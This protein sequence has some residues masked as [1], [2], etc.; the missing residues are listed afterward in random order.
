MATSIDQYNPVFLPEEPPFLTEKSG[1]PQS[2]GSQ[3]VGH[4]R[5]DPVHIDARLFCLWQLRPQRE[6][7][8][9]VVQLLGLRGPWQLQVCRDTDCICCRSYGPIRVFFQ[10]SCSWRSEGLFGQSFSIG[11]PIQALR[12]FLCLEIGRAHV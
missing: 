12:G 5:S 11:P 2:T 10:A 1:R 3:R 4:D 9:K 6:L 7:S 8:M